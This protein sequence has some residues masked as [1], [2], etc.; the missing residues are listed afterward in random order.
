ML[1]AEARR[2]PFRVIDKDTRRRLLDYFVLRPPEEEKKGEVNNNI[3]SSNSAAVEGLKIIMAK[4]DGRQGDD[5][6]ERKKN[7]TLES[8]GRGIRFSLG[9]RGGGTTPGT[10]NNH[11]GSG[12]TFGGFFSLLPTRAAA[13]S[14][15]RPSPAESITLPPP[16][17]A[18][19]PPPTSARRE[20]SGGG[21]NAE[22]RS[23]GDCEV[24]FSSVGGSLVFLLAVC[25]QKDSATM[26]FAYFTSPCSFHR[27]IAV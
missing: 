19:S 5:E 9:S 25:N 11:T 12:R 14:S 10:S 27:S 22:G 4:I 23:A 7:D 17:D 24:I 18:S 1:A 13:N 6:E 3:N 2:P 26:L 21:G 16:P 20:V 15:P 8:S